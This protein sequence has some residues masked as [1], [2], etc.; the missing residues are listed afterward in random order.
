VQGEGATLSAEGNL[1]GQGQNA[2]V[3]LD[4]LPLDIF[5][6]LVQAALP[7]LHA[8]REAPSTFA[9]V[10]K[11]LAALQ[12]QLRR[13]VESLMGPQGPLAA[14]RG[15]PAAPDLNP[16]P[17]RGLLHVQ[18][19]L[20]G[21]VDRPE[22]EVSVRVDDAALG[23][24]RLS[25]ASARGCIG[26]DGVARLQAAMVPSGG[27]GRVEM[28]CEVHVPDGQNLVAHLHIK[29]AGMLVLSELAGETAR[30]E[31]GRANVHVSAVG[32][33]DNPQVTADVQFAR[34]RMMV[35]HLREPLRGLSGRLRLANNAVSVTN[36]QASCGNSGVIKVGG[37]LPLKMLPP[38]GAK[39]D[40]RCHVLAIAP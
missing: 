17:I 16:A 28:D 14:K 10:T 25:E 26:G 31:E 9:P 7:N 33:I 19:S 34:G 38:S 4:G 8:S 30:W 27:S 15:G 22:G 2:T 12:R 21:P 32:S 37:S 18:G 29:D 36:V 35:P 23:T 13:S 11:P 40:V 1:L 6:P 24:L 20:T 39:A 3:Q 5:R